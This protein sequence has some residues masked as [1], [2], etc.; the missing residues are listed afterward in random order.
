MTAAATFHVMDAW[1]GCGRA[2]EVHRLAPARSRKDRGIEAIMVIGDLE[3][4]GVFPF[5]PPNVMMGA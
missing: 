2:G 3:V 4:F 5:G 1:S